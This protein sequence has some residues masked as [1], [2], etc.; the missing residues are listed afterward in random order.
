MNYLE[1]DVMYKKLDEIVAIAVT[2]VCECE[3][4]KHVNEI[5]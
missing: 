5:A 4:E 2:E 3:K 1:P